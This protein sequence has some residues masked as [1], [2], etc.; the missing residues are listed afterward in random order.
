M[1]SAQLRFN[2]GDVQQ[3]DPW[4]IL[5]IVPENELGLNLGLDLGMDHGINL[6]INLGIDLGINLEIQWMM[7]FIKD[8]RYS[9]DVTPQ[10][11]SELQEILSARHISHNSM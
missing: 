7:Y 5:G 3:N 9:S 10:N 1:C 2:G 8:C 6:I 4:S 11:T